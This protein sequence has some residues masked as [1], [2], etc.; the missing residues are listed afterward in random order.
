MYQG[1]CVSCTYTDGDMKINLDKGR[2]SYFNAHMKSGGRSRAA[3][4]WGP[5]GPPAPATTQGSRAF[6]L[7]VGG[8]FPEAGRVQRGRRFRASI[9]K[10][11]VFGATDPLRELSLGTILVAG[12][13]FAAHARRVRCYTRSG[14]SRRRSVMMGLARLLLAVLVARWRRWPSRPTSRLCRATGRRGL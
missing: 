11:G 13:Q 14:D 8:C 10:L 1:S 6:V 12:A 2:N 7:A 4:Y 3:R 5:R 9:C